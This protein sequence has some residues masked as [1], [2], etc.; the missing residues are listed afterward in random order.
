MNLI[1]EVLVQSKVDLRVFLTDEK[2]EDFLQSS[3]I[4]IILFFFGKG[5][6][7]SC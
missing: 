7:R 6:P 4:L 2:S 5:M 3:P 1:C